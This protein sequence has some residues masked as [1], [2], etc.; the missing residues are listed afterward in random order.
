MEIICLFVFVLL[1]IFVAHDYVYGACL[2]TI[3]TL[4]PDILLI[5]RHISVYD[6]HNKLMKPMNLI[7]FSM[8][9]LLL[10]TRKISGLII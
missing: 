4:N 6:V 9:M 5:D 3:V 1:F 10:C 2:N 7:V 8:R